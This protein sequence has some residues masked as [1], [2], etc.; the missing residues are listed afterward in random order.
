MT[1]A[2]R[3]ADGGLIDRGTRI[4]FTYDGQRYQGNA[5]DTLASALLANGVRLV[6]RSFKYHRPRG[7]VGSGAEEPNALIQLGEGALTEPNTRATQIELFE[8]LVANSQNA[9]PGVGFDIGGINNIVSKVIPAGFYYKTFMWPA[10]SW[11]LYEKFIRGAAGLGKAPTEPDPDIYEKRRVHCDVLVVGAGPAGL[12]AARAAGASGARIILADEQSGFGGSLLSSKATVDGKSG[13]QWAAD[14]T[15]ELAGQEEV[16][17]LPRT[18][19]TGYYDHNFLVAVERITDHLPFADRKGPRQRVWKIRA[20]QVILATGAIERP[21]VFAENDRPGVML[22]DA[23]KTYVN[24]FG[25]RP[26]SRAVVFTNNDSASIS[27]HYHTWVKNVRA[28]VH[29]RTDRAIVTKGRRNDEFI[30]SVL[31]RDYDSV[32]GQQGLDRL[33]GCLGVMRL[34][35]EE[36]RRDLGGHVTG[37]HAVRIY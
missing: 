8:G 26:G 31:Y 25:A 2:F 30:E 13:A 28:E 16:R 4:N 5:G 23:A 12:A 3:N 22:A 9:W 24:R 10:K 15:Q 21:L 1:Q 29:E 11:M 19:V 32:T 27:T 34:H 7:I 37:M 14:V 33:D 20:K 6:G 35:R 17:L 36:Y 18:T